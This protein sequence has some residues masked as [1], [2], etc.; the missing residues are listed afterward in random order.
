VTENGHR[1]GGDVREA[2]AMAR[3][4]VEHHFGEPPRRMLY[5]A[6]GLTNFVFRVQHADG[7]L[8]VRISPD[9][10][11]LQSFIKEQWAT[12][13]AREAGVPTPD[14]LEVGNEVV[15]YPYMIARSVPG[16][17]A[18]AHPERHRILR[19][20][21]R[22]AALVNTIRTS[23]FGA[24]FDWSSNLLS[25]N[26]TWGDFLH[27][28]LTLDARLAILERHGML[29]EEALA[30][31]RATLEG[32]DAG[33]LEPALTHG[34]VR[35]KN[36]IVDDGGEIVALLDWEN[37]TSN[38]A[39]HWELSIALHDL[40]IDEKQVFLSGY[41]LSERRFAEI[42]PAVKAINVVN[43][44]PRILQ[45]VESNDEATIEQYRTRL[46]GALDLYSL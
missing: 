23:G 31:L 15:P 43:Y 45:L 16:H 40:S 33:P 17:E 24:T 13:R 19:E 34:D 26:E 46:S 9:P 10:S 14:I 21:G 30:R 8:V 1:P 20:L 39:P 3:R 32:L 41:G 29:S 28:E 42:A 6:S 12:A 35:L 36:A 18:T 4:I 25:R 27:A 38:V 7:P 22:L 2:K 44:A 11:K 5:Q 37:C